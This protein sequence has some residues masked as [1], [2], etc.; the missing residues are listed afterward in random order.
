MEVRLRKEPPLRFVLTSSGEDA[1][2]VPVISIG[3]LAAPCTLINTL[4]KENAL[5]VEV[6]TLKSVRESQGHC[7]LLS[8]Q[9]LSVHKPP[10]PSKK[11]ED[12]DREMKPTMNLIIG[13]DLVSTMEAEEE[14]GV[15]STEE[16]EDMEV[17]G[18]LRGRHS[19][20]SNLIT[21]ILSNSHNTI[22]NR[23]MLPNQPR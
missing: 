23:L 16:E 11:M 3:L 5:N 19:S 14:A 22:L 2:I 6:V 15:V 8:P 9:S 17:I 12:L 20:L 1:S 13:P 4:L 10:N 7:P 21:H 18:T